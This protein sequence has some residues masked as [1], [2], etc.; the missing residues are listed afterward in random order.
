MKQKVLQK[1]EIDQEWQLLRAWLK[2]NSKTIIGKITA[3]GTGGNIN[4]LFELAKKLPGE[5]LSLPKLIKIQKTVDNMSME[6]RII[7][8]QLNPDRADVIIPASKIYISVMKWAKCN[9][10]LVPNV[11]LKDG[12]MIELYNRRKKVKR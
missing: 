11:G 10:I 4:K 9:A 3:I 8:L 6:D 5:E 2:N 7:E 12:M 1:K